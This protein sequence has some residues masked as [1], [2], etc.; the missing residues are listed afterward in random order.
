VIEGNAI[1]EE[2][3]RIILDLD[4]SVANKLSE[5]LKLQSVPD[6]LPTAKRAN[7]FFMLNP[8]NFIVSVLGPDVMTFTKVE[9]DPKISEMIPQLLDIYQRWLK[10][11]QTHHAAFTTMEGMAE[12][13]VQ[14]ILKDDKDF[15]NYLTTYMGTDFSS[16]QVRKSMGKDFTEVVF[17]KHGKKSFQMLIEN[18]PSTLELKEPQ[19]YLKRVV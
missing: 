9:V 6:D 17:D 4:D 10:P 15:Q 5:Y 14:N 3:A 2:L 16:Y 19:R 12:F 7:L 1:N 13:A 8:D 18:P 11:I